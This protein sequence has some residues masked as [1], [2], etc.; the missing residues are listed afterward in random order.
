MKKFMKNG[1]DSNYSTKSSYNEEVNE[2]TLSKRLENTNDILFAHLNE[3]VLNKKLVRI[4]QFPKKKK[5]SS[6]RTFSLKQKTYHE[7]YDDINMEKWFRNRIK[8]SNNE[9]N[10]KKKIFKLYSDDKNKPHSNPSL[11]WVEKER[12]IYV[13]RNNE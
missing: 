11:L 12:G 7:E 4:N 9:K 13:I 8:I 10:N 6:R 1:S 2:S 3:F 5:S